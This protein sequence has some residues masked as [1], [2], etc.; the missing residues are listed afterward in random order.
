MRDVVLTFKSI[1][2]QCLLISESPDD[3]LKRVCAFLHVNAQ[4]PFSTLFELGKFAKT[5]QE[6]PRARI[7]W[8]L[9]GDSYHQQAFEELLI[10][11]VR[12]SMA[13]LARHVRSCL[14]KVTFGIRDITKHMDHWETH[15]PLIHPE[16]L[17]D[18][19]NQNNF[20]SSFVF[21]NDNAVISKI[22]DSI[23]KYIVKEFQ[24]DFDRLTS[25]ITFDKVKMKAFLKKTKVIVEDLMC[26][27]HLCSG[28]PA[29]S[30]EVA[31]ITY[32]NSGSGML[33]NLIISNGTLMTEIQYRRKIVRF[34]GFPGFPK[35]NLGKLVSNHL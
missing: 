26:L 11:K 22:Q 1:I 33:R 19:A 17:I 9:T 31:S 10:D 14:T 32:T 13:G 30:P 28:M 27:I 4:S 5:N 25:T 29:R 12:V 20:R 2:C 8:V 16:K 23:T 7:E 35:K 24:S 18:D 34:S 15:L 3:R 6:K 21:N